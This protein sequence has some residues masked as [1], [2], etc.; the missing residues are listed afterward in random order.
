MRIHHSHLHIKH[1]LAL[2]VGIDGATVQLTGHQIV[3]IAVDIFTGLEHHI[4]LIHYQVL[5]I[6][7][8]ANRYLL[9]RE[10]IDGAGVVRRQ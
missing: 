9:V 1:I 8:A 7:L 6:G 3:G 4:V 10:Q 5:Q 2:A